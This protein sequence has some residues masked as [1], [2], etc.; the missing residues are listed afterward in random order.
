M[1]I[2][3]QRR[4]RP[5]DIVKQQRRGA[6]KKPDNASASGTPVWDPVFDR[7]P[8]NGYS[9]DDESRKGPDENRLIPKSEAQKKAGEL[10]A[11][12]DEQ[13]QSGQQQYVLQRDRS[14]V[15][16]VTED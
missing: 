13:R 2:G 12:P 16:G 11:S 14:P 15:I 8:V 9:A 10:C 7:G 6:E 3:M 1:N 5:P 4:G